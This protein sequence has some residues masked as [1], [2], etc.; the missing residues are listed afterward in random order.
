[1]TLTCAITRTKEI[2]NC[3]T[4]WSSTGRVLLRWRD[5]HL[6][7][8]GSISGD[9]EW[10]YMGSVTK[11][12]SADVGILGKTFTSGTY[13]WWL[14]GGGSQ[15]LWQLGDFI[16]GRIREARAHGIATVACIPLSGGVVELGSTDGIE[17]DRGLVLLAKSVFSSDGPFSG[18]N[19]WGSLRTHEDVLDHPQIITGARAWSPPHGFK[20]KQKEEEAAATGQGTSSVSGKISYSYG[21]MRSTNTWTTTANRRKE[22][23]RTSSS[24]REKNR[25]RCRPAM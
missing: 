11:S 10:H 14:S 18:E 13:S 21:K 25:R 20:G 8:A 3:A 16:D 5:G 24:S 15:D 22:M 7:P 23:E 9:C 17:E 19:H 12:Y 2:R 6:R 4:G 1:M